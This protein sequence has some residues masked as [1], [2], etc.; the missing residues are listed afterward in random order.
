MSG[1]GV[2]RILSLRFVFKHHHQHSCQP[3]GHLDL[4]AFNLG[5]D[6]L[7]AFSHSTFVGKNFV[8]RRPLARLIRYF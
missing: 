1:R 8:K 5:I 7:D 3:P 2:K 6:L 4:S